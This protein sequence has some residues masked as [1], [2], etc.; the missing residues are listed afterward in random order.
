LL[1]N[2]TTG[3]DSLVGVTLDGSNATLKLSQPWNQPG[4]SL[5]LSG[6]TPIAEI[7]NV[8]SVIGN[9][10]GVSAAIL[11]GTDSMSSLTVH[12]TIDQDFAGGVGPDLGLIKSGPAK[13]TLS[14]TLDPSLRLTAA[15]G[16][17][18][19]AGGPAVVDSLTQTGGNLTLDLSDQYTPPL[20]LT[21]SYSHTAGSLR[22]ILP[23]AGALVPGVPY[24]L[25]AY[26]GSLTGQPPVEFSQAVPATVNYG[27]GSNSVITV[28][29]PEAVELTLIATPP[30]A[31]SVS[32]GGFYQPD[33][34]AG[35]TAT[36]APGWKFAGWEGDGVLEADHPVS[37]VIMDASKTVSAYFITDYQA[38]T[39]SCGLND[40]EALPLADPD[41]DG[42]NNDLEFRFGF[43]PADPNSRLKLSI[44]PGA[45]GDLILT[46]NRVITGGT[47]TLE[48]ATSPAGPWD[49]EIPV[50]VT[51]PEWNYELSV[52]KTGTLGFLRLR[53][54]P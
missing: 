51:I 27:S 48:T 19:L 32:G 49:G 12:Q 4:A 28:T 31:G 14:G 53:Y 34:S 22:V 35:I 15:Q 39:K 10:S 1:N 37:S 33:S 46:I 9:L 18:A 6:G 24:P 47:F 44:R 7:G 36:A 25:V 16:E 23:P 40:D 54:T 45:G 38:W 8:S 13:L 29:F 52:P 50:P 11:R 30:E 26:T 2:H 42:L 20:T 43:D 17:L 21:G 41:A 5:A 3:L